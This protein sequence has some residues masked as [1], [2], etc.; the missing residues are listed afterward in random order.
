[1]KI[2]HLILIVLILSIF[3]CKDNSSLIGDKLFEEGQYDKAIDAYNKFLKLQPRHVKSIYNRGRCYQELGQFE[4][5]LEDFNKVVDLD[6]N[7][8]NALLSIGQEL[9]REE[10]FKSVAFY[11]EK[12]LERNPTNSMAHY[13]M[14]R[15]NHRQ[16]YIRDAMINYN[17]A[18]NLS[19]NFG[20]A[21]LHRGA[22]KLYQKKFSAACKDLAKAAE[23]N[24]E[25]AETALRKN[26]R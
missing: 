24:T 12:V 2:K 1:M 20:E 21:Y 17:S 15:S 26:C 7:N 3:S 9:Y 11:C 6:S 25:G 23:L 5:A 14:G 13:L 10:K 19:P 4:K 8:E 22:L 16:G 18:I